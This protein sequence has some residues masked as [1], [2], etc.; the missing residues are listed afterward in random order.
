MI[1]C[2]IIRRKQ[3]NVNQKLVLNMVDI[4][5]CI[6]A[7][8]REDGM[9]PDSVWL[10]RGTKKYVA[11]PQTRAILKNEYGKRRCKRHQKRTVI[12]VFGRRKSKVTISTESGSEKC[13][14]RVKAIPLQV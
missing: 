2:T 12:R 1:I 13:R 4:K 5:F 9:N 10:L 7:N 6:V 11:P 3:I 8:K 14:T